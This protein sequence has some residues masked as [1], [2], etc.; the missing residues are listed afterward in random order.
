VLKTFEQLYDDPNHENRVDAKARV[1]RYLRQNTIEKVA[2][3]K[4]LQQEAEVKLLA[5]KR[6]DLKIVGNTSKGQPT[7]FATNKA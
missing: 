4:K 7:V 2:A 1:E 5:T 3:A 6:G